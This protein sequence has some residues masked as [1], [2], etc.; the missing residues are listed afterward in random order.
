MLKKI[1]QKDLN[2]VSGGVVLVEANWHP[3]EESVRWRIGK[4]VVLLNKSTLDK[5]LSEPP[6]TTTMVFYEM[7][8]S[9]IPNFKNIKRHYGPANKRFELR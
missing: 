7:D 3:N 2:F 9:D 1:S 8:E 4:E 5:I 6:G